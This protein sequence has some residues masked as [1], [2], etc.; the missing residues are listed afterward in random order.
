MKYSFHPDAKSELFE[1]IN[2]YAVKSG[3]ELL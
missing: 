2:Y 1:A 3:T